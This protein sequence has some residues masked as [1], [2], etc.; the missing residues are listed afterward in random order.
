MTRIWC[1]VLATMSVALSVLTATA[2]V[3]DYLPF[4]DDSV[5]VEEDLII[6]N[7]MGDVNSDYSIN[8]MDVTDLQKFIVR[9]LT[10][11]DRP[12]A[13]VDGNGKINMVDVTLIQKYMAH[14]I[15]DFSAVSLGNDL[16]ISGI[17]ISENK[18]ELHSDGENYY[19]I[20][21]PEVL[22]SNEIK[23]IYPDFAVAMNEFNK[24]Y[25]DSAISCKDDF[26]KNLGYFEENKEPFYCTRSL[27]L[28]YADRNVVSFFHDGTY[29][30]GG[31]H[32]LPMTYGYT[33]STRTGRKVKLSN[34]VSD[35]D[36]MPKVLC[37]VMDEKYP[38]I[39]TKLHKNETLL[40]TLNGFH[41]KVKSGEYSDYL[42]FMHDDGITIIFLPRYIA[43]YESGTFTAKIRYEDYPEIFYPSYLK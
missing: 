32:V 14:L 2:D 21:Y 9:L 20:T 19:T 37:E 23:E 43:P 17:S 40:T 18:I 31:S 25:Y 15:G 4:T 27:E 13:D 33:F 5:V 39:L 6:F 41:S 7:V 1:G 8:M 10:V 22:L 3:D 24:E 35:L 29:Y 34:V 36:E 11:I 16:V 42:W 26:D 28:S 38:N 30:I 12:C